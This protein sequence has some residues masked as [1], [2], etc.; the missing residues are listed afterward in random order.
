MRTK[1]DTLNK[2]VVD[3]IGLLESS[4]AALAIHIQQYVDFGEVGVDIFPEDGIGIYV[5]AHD[6]DGLL[7]MGVADFKKLIIDGRVSKDDFIN[8]C[9]F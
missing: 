5:S 4:K 7:H 8:G 9:Y 2:K 1:I 3:A 6:I